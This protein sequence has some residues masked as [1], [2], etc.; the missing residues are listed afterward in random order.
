MQSEAGTCDRG[1]CEWDD[2]GK[3]LR[4]TP[5][6]IGRCEFCGDPI[7]REEDAQ[8]DESGRLFDSDKCEAKA[9][10]YAEGQHG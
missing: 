5:H 2:D 6:L 1:C 10:Y 4:Y 8:R 3:V 7:T 9:R